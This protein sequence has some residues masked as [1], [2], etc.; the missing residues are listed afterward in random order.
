MEKAIL[1]TLA[2]GDI[3]DF[4]MKAW[5]IHKW[6]INRKSSLQEI[7]KALLSLS[8][9]GKIKNK[10]GIYYLK[11]RKGLLSIRQKRREISERRISEARWVI[12]LLK[13]IPWIKLVG[14]SGDLAMEN[15]N[16]KSDIDLFIVSQ[17]N[18]L[19]LSRLIS[20]S[21]LGF[22]GKRRRREDK[23][24]TAAGKFCVNL[25][26][27]EDQISFDK[28]DLYLAHEILQ[29]KLLWEREGMYSRL[30]EE[31][32]W[33]FDTLPNWTSSIEREL[34]HKK[35]K[36]VKNKHNY[37]DNLNRILGWMQLR[38]MGGLSGSE[39]IKSGALYFHPEDKR[40]W[41]M[42][43]FQRRLKKLA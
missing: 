17:K 13:V 15:S 6:L 26:V 37:L 10:K 43:E 39:Q 35:R 21:I 14:I 38:Y 40:G 7:E 16:E 28:K 24:D 34:A 22:L 31:N 5:E 29:M 11:S 27:E 36:N 19:Y 8:N 20:L 12:G 3:F 1:K 42:A 30:L 41:V 32:S 18:R 33:V 9:K 23:E 2:Y 4:P 25:L